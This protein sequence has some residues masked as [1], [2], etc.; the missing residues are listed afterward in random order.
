VQC[1]LVVMCVDAKGISVHYLYIYHYFQIISVGSLYCY[2]D[3][4]SEEAPL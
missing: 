2:S 1:V 3:Q 4:A